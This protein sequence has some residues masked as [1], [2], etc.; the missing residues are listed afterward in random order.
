[1]N[2]SRKTLVAATIGSAL[3]LSGCATRINHILVNPARYQ[4]RSV[5]VEGTVDRSIGALMVGMYRVDD[6]TGKLT[7]LSNG[8]V[9]PRG[10]KVKVRGTVVG[11]FNLLGRDFGTA[12]REQGRRASR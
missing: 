8:A 1:M 9:P 7:V 3:F 6:G 2:L 5:Q 4:N 12:M 11:G 10:S